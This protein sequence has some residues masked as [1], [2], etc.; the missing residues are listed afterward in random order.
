MPGCGD[1]DQSQFT[2]KQM[3]S[4][5]GTCA[6]AETTVQFTVTT[7][8]VDRDPTNDTHR[9]ACGTF[10]RRLCDAAGRSDRPGAARNLRRR[11][12]RIG[13]PPAAAAG[14]SVTPKY[15]A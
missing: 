3:T 13:L 6:V 14:R 7:D 15:F 5:N 9:A 12:G 8:D 2:Y 4:A 10:E 1:A 11:A